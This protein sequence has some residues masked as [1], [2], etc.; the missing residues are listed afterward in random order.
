MSVDK[1]IDRM[2]KGFQELATNPDGL[3][4]QAIITD[5]SQAFADF[6]LAFKKF[7]TNNSLV[8]P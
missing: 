8:D 7:V 3:V 2:T 1:S 4:R 5:L 6:K